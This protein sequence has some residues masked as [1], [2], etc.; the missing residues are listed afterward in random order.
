MNLLIAM[1]TTTYVKIMADVEV[2]FVFPFARTILYYER[3]AR[4][5]PPSAD[6]SFPVSQCLLKRASG[7]LSAQTHVVASPDA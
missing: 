3:Q 4:Q 1:L 5:P 6:S 7:V 2:E